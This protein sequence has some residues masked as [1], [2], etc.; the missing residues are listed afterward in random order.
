MGSQ[1]H[2]V[3]FR[4]GPMTLHLHVGPFVALSILLTASFRLGSAAELNPAAVAE[5]K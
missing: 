2:S 3:I 4:E 1:T 5:E